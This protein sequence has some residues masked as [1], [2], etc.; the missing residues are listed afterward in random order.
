MENKVCLVT[1]ATNGIGKV[2]ALELA[3][4]GAMVVLAGRSAAKTDAVV[5]EIK[6]RS[7][8]DHAE[9]LVADLSTQ[10]GVR[11]LADAFKARYN[12]L[13]VLVN[14]AGAI[15]NERRE[16]ADGI[17]MT[18][19][20]NHLSYFLLTHLLLDVLKASAPAR[21]VNVSSNAHMG[22]GINFDDLEFKHGYMNFRVYAQSKLA[23]ILFTTELARRLQGTGVTANALHPGFVSSGFGRNDGSMMNIGMMLMRPFQISPEKGAETTLYLATS[24]EVE[25]VTGGYFSKRKPA[26][27]S[28]AARDQAAA[29]RLWAISEQ[30]TGVHAAELA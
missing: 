22:S 5:A 28:S 8:N 3:R 30:M 24:P 12:R 6:V 9:G 19:A 21:I 26:R 15:F 29:E 16:S 27:T 17:E 23:N 18:F 13:D 20:L 2:T 25:G 7:G 11:A 4:R 10:A 14:N 1:G